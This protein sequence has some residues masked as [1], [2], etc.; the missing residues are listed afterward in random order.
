MADYPIPAWLTPKADPASEYIQSYRAQTALNAQ[1]AMESQRLQ[2]QAQI[3][4]ME[5]QMR[6]EENQRRANEDASRIA[7]TK[8]YH[9]QMV[10][11]RQQELAKTAIV[12]NQ[13]AD[14]ARR[15]L[16][17]QTAYQAA[18]GDASD[19]D[20]VSRAILR[21]GA[22]MGA[23]G[24][25]MSAALKSFEAKPAAFVPGPV[26]SFPV[27]DEKG[28]AIKGV[29]ATQSPTLKGMQTHMAP[30]D[31]GDMTP[32]ER[33]QTVSYLRKEMEDIEKTY[34]GQMDLYKPKTEDQKQ[35]F[36][37]DKAR[38]EEIKQTMRELLPHVAPRVPATRTGTAPPPARALDAK[39]S[40][41][42]ED[43]IAAI[44]GR[45]PYKSRKNADAVRRAYKQRTGLDPD[46]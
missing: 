38:M 22:E 29:F 20:A 15:K 2:Q 44:E 14:A 26:Q 9:D 10:G 45:P 40:A 24:A 35:R 7:I 11:L 5:A 41:I 4:S 46:F 42:R 27:L 37:M 30:K 28:R 18:V 32:G 12:V 16:A 21:F 34:F 3:A 39:T 33:S 36:E 17:A 25:A 23:P 19:A 1:L 31:V 43:A 6:A 8:A 13:R